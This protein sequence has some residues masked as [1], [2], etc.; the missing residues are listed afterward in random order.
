MLRCRPALAVFWTLFILAFASRLGLTLYLGQYQIWDN[1]E[2]NRAAA[3]LVRE[4]TL[5]DVFF[6]GFWAVG[7]LGPF[8]PWLLSLIYRCFGVN[9]PAGLLVQGM[10]AMASFALVVAGM[11]WLAGRLAL[12]R[13]AGLLAACTLILLPFNVYVETTGTWE[14]AEAGCPGPSPG[15]VLCSS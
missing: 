10:V 12:P 11:P 2:T 6:R 8:H 1:V 4:G 14:Q 13:G 15:L 5:G 3:C 7:D 9:T